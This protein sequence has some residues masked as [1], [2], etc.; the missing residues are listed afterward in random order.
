MTVIPIRRNFTR[1]AAEAR[2]ISTPLRL[3]IF[4][5]SNRKIVFSIISRAPAMIGMENRLKALS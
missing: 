4:C 1:A 5:S 3:P 2:N